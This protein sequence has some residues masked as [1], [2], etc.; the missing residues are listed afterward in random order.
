MKKDDSP[1]SNMFEIY[2]R[3]LSFDTRPGSLV[4]LVSALDN[5]DEVS[6]LKKVGPVQYCDAVLSKGTVG[7]FLGNLTPFDEPL[8]LIGAST[9]CIHPNNLKVITREDRNS[10]KNNCEGAVQQPRRRLV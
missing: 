1:N 3:S 5:Y 7:L 2:N 4:Q 8:V 10:S 9:Y 6:C